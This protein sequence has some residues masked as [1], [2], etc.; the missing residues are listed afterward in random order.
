MGFKKEVRAF[1]AMKDTEWNLIKQLQKQNQDL[2][3]RLM[4]RSFGE[5]KTYTA[6]SEWQPPDKETYDPT[7]DETGA[8]TVIEQ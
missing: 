6:E 5:L 1:M 8:G 2:M 7:E 4:A 3:D